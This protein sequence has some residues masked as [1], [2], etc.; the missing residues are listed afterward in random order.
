MNRNLVFS[1]AITAMKDIFLKK[2]SGRWEIIVEKNQE[3][4]RTPSVMQEDMQMVINN[5]PLAWVTSST[6][7]YSEQPGTTCGSRAQLQVLL[8]F[9]AAKRSLIH[10]RTE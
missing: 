7:F 4:L 6:Y 2:P 5:L 10:E 9:D 3:V 8:T 1:D